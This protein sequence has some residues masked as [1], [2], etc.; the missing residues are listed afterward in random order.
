[1]NSTRLTPNDYPLLLEQD[2]C[3]PPSSCL[4]PDILI[5]GSGLGTYA[6]NYLV[7]RLNA[8][9]SRPLQVVVVDSGPFDQIG[10]IG[11]YPGFQRRRFIQNP[12]RMGGKTLVWG[13]SVPRPRGALLD[14]WP[15]DRADI[16][17]RLRQ[18]EVEVGENDSIEK[19]GRELEFRLLFQL[20]S[21]LP[22]AS[23]GVAPLAL[24]SSGTR[25]TSTKYI[26]RLR[27]AG[28]SFISRFRV[29]SLHRDGRQISEVRGTWFDGNSY[30]LRPRHVVLGVGAEHSIPLLASFVPDCGKHLRDHHRIDTHGLLPSGTYGSFSP[31][32]LGVAVL[33]V[34]MEDEIDHIPFHIEIKIAPVKH[35]ARRVHAII[36]QPDCNVAFGRHHFLPTSSCLRDGGPAPAG[37]QRLEYQR[38]DSSRDDDARRTPARATRRGSRA[39]DRNAGDSLAV[40]CIS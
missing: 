19:S 22:D 15:W 24:N 40:V 27:Q 8:N 11:D 2:Y 21:D 20:R 10:H 37:R 31:D 38:S 3:S 5:I 39:V 1:M 25:W 4:S 18:L 36:R 23:V 12:E 35:V 13:L 6:A 17:E 7:N 34:E 16:D 32:E 30:T 9:S 28:V 29:E 33:I 14:Q 26:P